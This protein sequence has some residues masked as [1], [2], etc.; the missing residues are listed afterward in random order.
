MYG[1]AA[2]RSRRKKLS[3]AEGTPRFIDRSRPY[4]IESRYPWPAY[5]MQD[6]YWFAPKTGEIIGEVKK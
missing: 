2:R 1:V 5:L 6:G 4:T 3:Q